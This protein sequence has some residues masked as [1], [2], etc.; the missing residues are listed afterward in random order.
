[1]R[2]LYAGIQRRFGRMRRRRK[3]GRAYDM[4]LEIA[5]VL[6]SNANI[7]D[8]GCGNGFIA[9]HLSAMLGSRVVGLDVGPATAAAINYLRFDGRNFPFAQQSFDAVLLCYVLHHAADARSVLNEV[10]RVLDQKGLL[11]IYEDMPDGWCD[12]I[13][14]NVHNFLWRRRTGPCTFRVAERWKQLFNSAG[15]NVLADRQL[16]RWRN[17]S[18]PVSRHFF[19]LQRDSVLSS[20]VSIPS[21]AVVS[22]EV[23]T[24]LAA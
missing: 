7:L 14:C 24:D 20:V 21:V 1:M 22:N 6:P 16:S 15:F 4:A 12:R 8:V 19:V 2:T 10:A 13:V 23:E 5:R 9:H 3:V 18:H 11:I 17:F